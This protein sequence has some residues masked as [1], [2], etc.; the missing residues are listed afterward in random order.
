MRGGE[1]RNPLVCG[2]ARLGGDQ[3]GRKCCTHVPASVRSRHQPAK[4]GFIRFTLFAAAVLEAFGMTEFA[5]FIRRDDRVA[6]V[7]AQFHP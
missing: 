7:P 2:M 6:G 4:R 1:G 5:T 3:R